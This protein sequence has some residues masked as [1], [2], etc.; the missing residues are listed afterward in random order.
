MEQFT[1]RD[2][3]NRLRNVGAQNPSGAAIVTLHVLMFDGE[4]VQW[5]V[6]EPIRLE[7]R[8]AAQQ[9]VQFLNGTLEGEPKHVGLDTRMD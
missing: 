3:Q 1:W 8:R 7:P 9:F 4:P 6:S 5:V 2:V